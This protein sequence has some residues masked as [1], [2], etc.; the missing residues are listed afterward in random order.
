VLKELP[1]E[2]SD[3]TEKDYARALQLKLLK[4][5]TEEAKKKL[6]ESSTSAS[7]SMVL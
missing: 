4:Y 7:T 5:R 2:S 1:T 6:L 3:F